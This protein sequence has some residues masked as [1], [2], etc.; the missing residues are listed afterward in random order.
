[1]AKTFDQSGGVNNEGDI[2]AEKVAGHDIVSIE[3]IEHYYASGAAASENQAEMKRLEALLAQGRELLSLK[4]PSVIALEKFRKDAAT[5]KASALA[6]KKFE[7]TP[8]EVP[9]AASDF[10][11]WL[12]YERSTIDLIR[13]EL[14]RPSADKLHG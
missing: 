1:V 8:A 6:F 10:I 9:N 13:E 5:F 14:E 7:I 3:K 11:T 2:R 12:N 4:I